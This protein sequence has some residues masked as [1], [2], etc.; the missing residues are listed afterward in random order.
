MLLTAF[1]QLFIVGVIASEQGGVN[2]AEVNK[3]FVI[4][5]EGLYPLFF[6]S[7]D[8]VDTGE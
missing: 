1:W 8:K 2:A 5:S 4:G 6:R 3:V 7:V